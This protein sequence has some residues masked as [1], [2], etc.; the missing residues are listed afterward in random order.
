MKTI[1]ILLSSISIVLFMAVSSQAE[2]W[3]GIVP[4]RSTRADVERM[5]GAGSGECNCLY[6]TNSEHLVILYS[7]LVG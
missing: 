4:L 3:R 7:L 5:L 6:Q 1:N 2:E